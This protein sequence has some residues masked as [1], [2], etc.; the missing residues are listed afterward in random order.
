MILENETKK[1]KKGLK[2]P[3]TPKNDF[4]LPSTRR[5]MRK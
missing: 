4:S 2:D 1:R 5:N 3:K